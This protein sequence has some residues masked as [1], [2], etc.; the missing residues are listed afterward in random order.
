MHQHY[1]GAT[2]ESILANY[3]LAAKS[4]TRLLTGIPLIAGVTDT[5]EN[6]DGICR[7]MQECGVDYAEL[8]PYNRMAGSKYPLAGRSYAPPFDTQAV[9]HT[10]QEIFAAYG[11]ETKIL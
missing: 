4:G 6:I 5:E 3:R 10:R 2:N 8:L 9:P 7:F 1:T 11:I